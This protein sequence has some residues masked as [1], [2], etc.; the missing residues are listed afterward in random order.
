MILSQQNI[1]EHDNGAEGRPFR[2]IGQHPS[3]GPELSGVGQC[4]D[5]VKT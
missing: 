2:N 1:K 3:R 4:R 5:G